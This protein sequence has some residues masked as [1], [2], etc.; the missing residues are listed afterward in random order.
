MYYSLSEAKTIMIQ[1]CR[2]LLDKELVART[3]G[4]ISARISENEMLITPSGL[5]YETL[6]HDDFVLVN[7][8]DLSHEEGK[9]PSSEKGIHAECYKHNPSAGFVIHTHQAFASAI[10][11]NEDGFKF[12]P[13][14]S[15]GLPGTKGLMRNVIN[16]LN[17]HPTCKAF[18]LNR[19]GALC[20]GDSY[21]E[22]FEIADEIEEKS[23]HIFVEALGRTPS[24]NDD[25][26]EMTKAF[27]KELHPY[28]D[29]YAQ[30]FRYTIDLSKSRREQSYGDDKESMDMVLMKNCCAALYARYLE[31]KPLGVFDCLLQRAFYKLKYSKLARA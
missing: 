5:A 30:M 12:A 3:W 24:S 28:L 11:L 19:H 4:N 6:G 17:E 8:A 18:L 7:I 2:T 23:R 15:Y 20:I 27:Y 29:D 14:V 13:C 22:A 1:A 31:Q 16:A 10:S 26:Y 21:G 9:K 25:L